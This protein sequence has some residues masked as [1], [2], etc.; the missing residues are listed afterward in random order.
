MIIHCPLFVIV[1]RKRVSLNLGVYRNLHHQV[2][3]KAKINFKASVFDQ[4]RILPKMSRISIR[5]TLYP[6]TR[7]RMDVANVCSIV[8]KY[9]SDVLVVMGKIPDDDYHHVVS[10]I[11]CFGE[12]DR[13]RPRVDAEIMEEPCQQ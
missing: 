3:S 8:D 12:V 2:N 5:Y 7:R 13:V 9:L 10:V 6:P 11:Y 1:G 4:V